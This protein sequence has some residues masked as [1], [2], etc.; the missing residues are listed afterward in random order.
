LKASASPPGL[1]LWVLAEAKAD[2]VV[3]TALELLSSA[4]FVSNPTIHSYLNNMG[5]ILK[6]EN[7]CLGLH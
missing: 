5:E 3:L 1:F 6:H 2:G 7:R 4:S